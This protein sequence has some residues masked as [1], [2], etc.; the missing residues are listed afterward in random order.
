LNTT[1]NGV[2]VERVHQFE[3]EP[4]ST[5]A[6]GLDRGRHVLEPTEDLLAVTGP[7]VA[8]ERGTEILLQNERRLDPGVFPGGEESL[9]GVTVFLKTQRH[10]GSRKMVFDRSRN[11]YTATRPDRTGPPQ[12]PRVFVERAGPPSTGPGNGPAVTAPRHPTGNPHAGLRRSPRLHRA[13]ALRVFRNDRLE[14][15]ERD[16]CG[17]VTCN[18]RGR[19]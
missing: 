7:V 5:T 14:D 9:R 19:A 3:S 4:H 1:R 13:L 16:A 10:T 12:E 8:G 6:A 18:L 17:D 11:R 15:H 2:V